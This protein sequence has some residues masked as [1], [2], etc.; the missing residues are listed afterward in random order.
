MSHEQHERNARH[1]GQSGTPQ[2]DRTELDDWRVETERDRA[3]ALQAMDRPRRLPRLMQHTYD[4]TVGIDAMPDAHE[5]TDLIAVNLHSMRND[6]LAEAAD[7][8]RDISAKAAQLLSQLHQS[9]GI[10]APRHRH[11]SFQYATRALSEAQN[12]IVELDCIIAVTHKDQTRRDAAVQLNVHE[13]TV[14]RWVKDPTSVSIRKE[15]LRELA[16]ELES[17]EP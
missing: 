12:I 9:R 4:G 10:T 6:D 16:V 5:P 3:E 17:Y 1:G 11:P 2:S 7:I 14:A 13:N 15:R 8:F